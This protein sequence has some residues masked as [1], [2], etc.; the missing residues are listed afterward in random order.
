MIDFIFFILFIFWAKMDPETWAKKIWLFISSCLLLVLLFSFLSFAFL[1]YIKTFRSRLT[2]ILLILQSRFCNL[3]EFDAHLTLAQSDIKGTYCERLRSK[4][5]N[6]VRIKTLL[7]ALIS[8]GK[9][10]AYNFST[11]FQYDNAIV[12]ILGWLQSYH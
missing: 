9:K 6:M 11:W 3:S 5:C 7:L 8:S 2:D 10:C 1:L 4:Y 12:W